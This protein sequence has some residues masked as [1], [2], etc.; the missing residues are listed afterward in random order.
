MRLRWGSRLGGI[1]AS[2]KGRAAVGDGG[3]CFG[4]EGPQEDCEHGRGGGHRAVVFV[5]RHG[6][7][8]VAITQ[9]IAVGEE[10]IFLAHMRQGARK[11]LG[12]PAPSARRI[13]F[14]ATVE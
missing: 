3:L 12:I 9:A 5:E 13:R 4:A 2:A 10:K 7:I 14:F 1:G 11:G 6:G 8:D